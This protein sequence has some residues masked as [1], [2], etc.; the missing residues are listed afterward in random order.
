VSEKLDPQKCP[1]R[2]QSKDDSSTM[3]RVVYCEL[4]DWVYSREALEFIQ[5]RN[6][7]APK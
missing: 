6:S 2:W 4:C 1:H 5:H 7:E 3:E